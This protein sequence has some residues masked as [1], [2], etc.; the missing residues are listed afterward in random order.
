MLV[1]SPRDL[2]LRQLA[3]VIGGV[4]RPQLIGRKHLCKN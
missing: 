1:I 4:A 3:S 2:T